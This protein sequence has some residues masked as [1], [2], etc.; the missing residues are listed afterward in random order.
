M[1]NRIKK[2]N[3]LYITLFL[4]ALGAILSFAT[5]FLLTHFLGSTEESRAILYGKI[6]Y[7]LGI[8]TI[9]TMVLKFGFVS[10]TVKNTQLSSDK[11]TVFSNVFFAFDLFSIIVFPLFFIISFFFLKKLE[12]NIFLIIVLFFASFFFSLSS[13]ISSFL[14]GKKRYKSSVFVETIIPKT[15]QLIIFGIFIILKQYSLLVD[16][17]VLIFALVY[18]FICLPFIFSFLKRTK[19]H[20]TKHEIVSLIIFFLISFEGNAGNSLIKVMQGELYNTTDATIQ[21]QYDVMLG[22]LSLSIQIVSMGTIFVGV[23]ANIAKPH[24][25][26]LAKNNQNELIDFFKKT[27]RL[28]GYISIPFMIAFM[29]ESKQVMSFFGVS[30]YPVFLIILAVYGLILAIGGPCGTLLEMSGMEKYELFSGTGNIVAFILFSYLLKNV[31]IYS[32]PIGLVI[33]TAVG[34]IMNIIFISI[35]FKKNPI[36]FTGLFYLLI[37]TIVSYIAFSKISLIS[38]F[39]GWLIV[40][41]VVGLALIAIGFICSPYKEDKYFFFKKNI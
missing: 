17:Y 26:F 16:L 13:L 4:S 30:S 31:T 27:I 39:Y 22:C 6:Q 14:L 3:G 7:Y 9:L 35:K 34:K 20:F 5:T 10:F 40:N 2:I 24:F 32:L 38:N 28:S 21:T 25:A 19:I 15:I 12:S 29:T 41:I 36:D 37:L 8:I 11:K 23:I 33:G 18:F 1:L